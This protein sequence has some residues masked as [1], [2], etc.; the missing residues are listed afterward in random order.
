MLTSD[1]FFFWDLSIFPVIPPAILP[2]PPIN[3]VPIILPAV[4]FSIITPSIILLLK[5]QK[6]DVPH[7]HDS[8]GTPIPEKDH[9]NRVRLYMHKRTPSNPIFFSVLWRFPEY[10]QLE[11]CE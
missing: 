4:F 9:A 7:F 11:D 5:Q 6:K 2:M 1:Y 10:D 8:G 3:I